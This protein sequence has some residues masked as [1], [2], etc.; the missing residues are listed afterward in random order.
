MTKV[1]LERLKLAIA[2]LGAGGEALSILKAIVAEEEGEKQEVSD[3]RTVTAEH[4]DVMTCE[5]FAAACEGGGF[6]DYDGY[7]YLG[8][9]TIFHRGHVILPSTVTDSPTKWEPPA[10]FT[11]VL[12]FNR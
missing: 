8:D 3:D 12:W 5:D 4:G 1:Q 6:I 9:G 11:H 10:G 2:R 7:G